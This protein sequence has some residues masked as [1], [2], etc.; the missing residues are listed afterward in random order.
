MMPLLI[1]LLTGN[2]IRAAGATQLADA[3]QHNSTLTKLDLGGK[4]DMI[5]VLMIFFMINIFCFLFIS[6]SI[7]FYFLLPF[8]S[9]ILPVLL[10]IFIGC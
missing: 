4:H 6:F 8:L 1:T 3:L 7:S 10:H 5:F 2:G 9:F